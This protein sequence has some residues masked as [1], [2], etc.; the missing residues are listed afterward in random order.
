MKK[1]MKYCIASALLIAI[2][3]YA[4]A[5]NQF[6]PFV[7]MLMSFL[8]ILVMFLVFREVVCWYWKINLRIELLTEIR[9]LLKNQAK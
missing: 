9:D 5:M 1:W 7:P 6:E 3:S 8:F 4:F 2:P